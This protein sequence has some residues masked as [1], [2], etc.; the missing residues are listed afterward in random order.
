MDTKRGE[1]SEYHSQ[2]EDEA[3]ISSILGTVFSVE[4]E[5]TI[6][7]VSE[8]PDEEA[9]PMVSER[10]DEEAITMV[11][12]RSNKEAVTMLSER[13]N[14]EGIT[15]FSAKLD[16]EAFEPLVEQGEMPS[17]PTEEELV[18]YPELEYFSRDVQ[19]IVNQMDKAQKQ[20][21]REYEQYFL[22]R[23]RQTG[24]M[25]PLYLEIRNIVKE[26]C[27]SMPGQMQDA[28][29]EA[30]A[31]LLAETKLKELCE[32]L[33]VP[34]PRYEPPPMVHPMDEGILGEEA[35]PMSSVKSRMEQVKEDQ[36][37]TSRT[38]RRVVPALVTTEVKK[39]IKPQVQPRLLSDTMLDALGS[40]DEECMVMRI[41][42]GRD[43]FYD[44]TRDDEELQQ[45]F[46][47]V[48][49]EDIPEGESNVDDLSVASLETINEI[50]SEEAS[51]LLTTYADLKMK[52]AETLQNM[53]ALIK[54]DD[55][56]PRQCYEIVKHVTKMEGDIPEI[57]Q[58]REEFDYESVKLILATGVRM[59]Q[60]Y[61]V[62]MRQRKKAESLKSIVK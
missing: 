19:A 50:E 59:K 5:E 31:Q 15:V 14:E 28:V 54:A 2:S 58:V 26:M 53:V 3:T 27:P 55:I 10:P 8:R 33:G 37:S 23:Y 20:E 62:N 30:R 60:V 43:P 11:S 51:R 57:A 21:F 48:G 52:E 12:E 16:E 25:Q 41:K 18:K 39:E 34:A 36:P 46:A 32:Q 61:D 6:P 17:I 7:M 49:P 47:E 9:I 56:G 29:V 4:K 1:M 40:G 24:N 42:R 38:V 45:A 22:T 44:L 13:P 35:V